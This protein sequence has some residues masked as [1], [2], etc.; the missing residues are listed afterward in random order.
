M[1]SAR[2][3]TGSLTGL[4]VGLGTGALAPPDD[5]RG[6]SDGT[7]GARPP[8]TQTAKITLPFDD[9]RMVVRLLG[10]HDEHLTLIEQR[11][12][13]DAVAHG[14]VVTLTG[15]AAGCEIA[16]TVLTQLYDRIKRGEQIVPGDVDGLI[17]HVS[18]APAE[19][20]GMSQVRTRK[21]VVTART[22]MQ[23]NYIRA[24]ERTDL[25]FG[26][27]P[28]GTG[29]TYLAVAFA[30][31]C[32]E[33]NLVERIILSRPAVEAG[34]RLG[35]LPGDMKEKVDPYLRPLY[36]A[37]YDMLPPDKVERDI[38]SGV[39]EIAPL[40]FMRGRT[41][42]HSFVILDEAQN[43]TSMQ[44]KMFLTR[45]GEGSKMVITGDPSQIDLPTGQ[46]SGLEEAVR[47]LDGV[48]GIEAIRFTGQD[49]VR[50]DLVARIVAA[51][52]KAGVGLRPSGPP[53]RKP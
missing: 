52:D 26:I 6:G 14:N 53:S 28:A 40:A 24:L 34:E 11:L 27:G 44:M 42:A 9:N 13:I 17:R 48:K 15:P 1:T 35:F 51:Y 25:V 49:V 36:D 23:S 18:S 21:R 32:L 16:K 29:K 3:L 33:R 45:I 38:A 30:A 37:L 8:T 47:L 10:G 2:G 12:G 39:I 31:Q 43:T 20:V 46:V 41:L 22:L 4:G 50:R 19:A 5:A 7:A